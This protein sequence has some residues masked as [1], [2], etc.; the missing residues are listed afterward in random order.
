MYLDK[1]CV[2][3]LQKYAGFWTWRRNLAAA[4]TGFQLLPWTTLVRLRD[5]PS[6][7]LPLPAL[8]PICPHSLLPIP[9]PLIWVSS[10]CHH[11]KGGILSA[12]MGGEQEFLSCASLPLPFISL[13]SYYPEPGPGALEGNIKSL[14]KKFWPGEH[15]LSSL[16]DHDP[17][18]PSRL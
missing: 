17:V 5:L 3:V 13:C 8:I 10:Y 1:V 12:Q 4:V 15:Q 18:S 2:C 6:S 7:F 11:L 16:T 14:D 9:Q